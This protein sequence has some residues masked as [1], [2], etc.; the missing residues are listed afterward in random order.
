MSA[1]VPGPRGPA[2]APEV[3]SKVVEPA[4][5]PFR[6]L[7]EV[8]AQL[9]SPGGCPWDREQTHE[10]LARYLLEETYEVLEAIDT[11]DPQA[12]REELGDVLLQVVLHAQVAADSGAFTITDV[13]SGLRTKLVTRHPHVFG[14]VK[15]SR[16]DEVLANWE[17]S[18]RAQKGTSVMHGI[19]S[20][21]PALSRAAKLVRR[22]A[23]TG[24]DWS[25][26]DAAAAKLDEEL[27]E[28][29]EE[30]ARDDPRADR[31]EAEVG[32]VL[33][34][35]VA[36]SRKVGVEPETALRRSADLFRRRFDA[37]E[38]MAAADGRELESL[39]QR[40]WAEYWDKAK[41]LED[42]IA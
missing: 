33:L 20:A 10:S 32:D 40:D 1:E 36:L 21:M 11:K 2:L 30:M 7:V 15:V 35:A 27:S 19:P 18:K 25:S 23:Q 31:L 3:A 37:M 17:K 42:S 12:L 13:V 34:A 24:F 6:R 16:S 8:I 9:R 26:A 28:L 38:E 29:H 4:P 39:S 41:G 14:D 5:E 22:A